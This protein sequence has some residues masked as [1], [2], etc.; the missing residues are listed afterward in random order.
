[1]SKIFTSGFASILDDLGCDGYGIDADRVLASLNN[2]DPLVDAK[3]A[4]IIT[5]QYYQRTGMI[6]NL[7]YHKGR[8]FPTGGYIEVL[9]DAVTERYKTVYSS[10]EMSWHERWVKAHVNLILNR[11]YGT[12]RP[13]IDNFLLLNDGALEH[14][15]TLIF[16]GKETIDAEQAYSVAMMVSSRNKGDKLTEVE[17]NL[18]RSHFFNLS[19]D[20][21]QQIKDTLIREIRAEW[22]MFSNLS[23]E[24][25]LGKEMLT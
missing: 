21:L 3:E 8:L 5:S 1:M 11:I 16:G 7:Q 22:E 24:E 2:S 20:E 9:F 17:T 6:G 14:I 19:H 23:T 25:I 12:S 18:I 13:E 4:K 15:I 10:Y